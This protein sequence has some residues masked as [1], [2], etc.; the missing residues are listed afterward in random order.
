MSYRHAHD[1]EV[2]DLIP[3][4]LPEAVLLALVIVAP[5]VMGGISDLGPGQTLG[6]GL[7]MKLNCPLELAV[8]S[9]RAALTVL[10]A[11]LARRDRADLN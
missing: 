7:Q 11:D 6:G 8:I 10:E 5:E 3:E 9:L 2:P 1:G 4:E